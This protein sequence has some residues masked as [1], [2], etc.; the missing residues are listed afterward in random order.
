VVILNEVVEV[1]AGREGRGFRQ[2]Q[3]VVCGLPLSWLDSLF[4]TLAVAVLNVN[5][6]MYIKS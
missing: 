5:R 1:G 4:A 3:S 2:S 6:K